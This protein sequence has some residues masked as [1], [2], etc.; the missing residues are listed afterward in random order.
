MA[1]LALIMPPDQNGVHPFFVKPSRDTSP[2]RGS[3]KPATEPPSTEYTPPDSLDGTNDAP[4]AKPKRKYTKRKTTE[5]S[6]PG[7]HGFLGL[8]PPVSQGKGQDFSAGP[9]S[10]VAHNE[11]RTDA[12]DTHR[13]KRR[14]ITPPVVEAPATPSTSSPSISWHKQLQAEAAKADQ[15]EKGSDLQVPCSSEVS[16][17][18]KE[19]TKSL[20][21]SKPPPKKVLRINASGR[22]SSPISKATQKAE[23]SPKRSR[24]RR[25]QKSKQYPGQLVVAI[26]YGDDTSRAEMG[27]KIN[28]VLAGNGRSAKISPAKPPPKRKSPKKPTHP[29]F[30][31]K[32]ASKSDSPSSS[33]PKGDTEVPSEEGKVRPPRQSA[34]TPG[35]LRAQIRQLEPESSAFEVTRPVFGSKKDSALRHPGLCEPIWPPSGAVH[36]RGEQS[37]NQEELHKGS[38]SRVEQMALQVSR[39]LKGNVLSIPRDEDL[40]IQLSDHLSNILQN[41]EDE[42]FVFGSIKLPS[43]MITT[44]K[45][46][47]NQVNLQLKHLLLDNQP[48]IHPAAT[49]LF[50]QIETTLTPFDLGECE[51]QMW[52]SKYAPTRAEDVLQSG[53]ET[54]VLRNW[55][56]SLTV[57]S[58]NT[59]PSDAA[60][61]DHTPK[62]GKNTLSKPARKKQ[63]RAEDL[64]D[65]IIGSDEEET[66]DMDEL[67]EPEDLPSSAG[68]HQ[69]RSMV[70]SL[71]PSS[72]GSSKPT[73]A[74][75]ISGPHGCGKTAAVYAVAKELGFEVFEI[76]SGSRRSG[77]DVLDRVKDMSENHL[78]QQIK[79]ELKQNASVKTHPEDDSTG[80]AA[81]IN[82]DGDRQESMNAFFKPLSKKGT[83]SK[84]S[85]ALTTAKKETAQP[86]Q[87]QSLILFE[88]V[89]VLFEEDKSFWETITSLAVL[90]K[91]PI[92]MTCT[93]ENLVGLNELSF[94]AIL[95]LSPPSIDL[96][97][98]Y[99]LLVAAREGHLIDRK[100]VSS[101]Y[102]SRGQDLRASLMD[103]NF[104]CQMAVGDHKGGLAWLYQRWPPGKDVDEQGR[105]LRV[106]SSD[107]LRAGLGWIGH[108][109]VDSEDHVGFCKEEELCQEMSGKWQVDITD[110]RNGIYGRLSPRDEYNRMSNL[111]ALQDLDG[112]FSL[113]SAVDVFTGQEL[114]PFPAHPLDPTLPDMA[115][116]ASL[117]YTKGYP[118]LHVEPMVHHSNFPA[119][120]ATTC[121]VLLRRTIPT[122]SPF[123][124]NYPIDP[125]TA[126]LHTLTNPPPQ[127]LMRNDFSALDLLAENP[128]QNL[129]STPSHITATSLDREFRILVED[130]APYVRSIVDYDLK[131]EA[132]RLRL[133]NLLSVGGERKR[134][135]TTR[136]SR[137]ALEG[138]RREV[139]RRE[140]WFRKELD[141]K[142]VLGTGGKDWAG[143][144]CGGS[145]R[146][147]S[148]EGE[149]ASV[150]SVKSLEDEGDS[151]I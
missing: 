112:H 13:R 40:V 68:S 25:N 61:H 8:A 74:V 116:K 87:K 130:L 136:A 73:N 44:G 67:T 12:E 70:R 110:D 66:A 86:Q 75:L 97:T 53:K 56:Q 7:L 29:F 140:R 11:E 121:Q 98:D 69:K 38:R 16:A 105:T 109:V 34:I 62:P 144:R 3:L 76:N 65:F 80:S 26:K 139:T 141:V 14:K 127:K 115:D 10:S 84:K 20:A 79:Q 36:I 142:G 6:Q 21:E 9:E 113:R 123:P 37:G 108:D 132:E 88:E 94:H 63:K 117:N 32:P 35:K 51:Q 59:F 133:S 5:K 149:G 42:S 148:R 19:E 92:I 15:E 1:A 104:W 78:V 111:T 64:D 27:K 17:A 119:R 145:L 124:S 30:L 48:S 58:T 41:P 100:A 85:V 60:K 83:A 131:L 138:G 28:D 72:S 99:M 55:L 150:G 125:T 143:L 54:A 128:Y 24:S 46:I 4:P 33:A 57:T 90:S 47:Q 134:I 137:S 52:V 147:E 22:L 151:G 101:L 114:S 146:G 77:K 2:I 135:R 102:R 95:R 91:R 93:D 106:A 107:T 126:I 71:V 122:P 23:N 45:G 89:D 39:K 81:G 96:A 129:W 49:S 50:S 18:A 82:V 43:R 31:G 118:L 103:L 120:L